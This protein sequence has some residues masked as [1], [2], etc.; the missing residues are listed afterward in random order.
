MG[1]GLLISMPVAPTAHTI[2]R[3]PMRLPARSSSTGK[4]YTQRHAHVQPS[5]LLPRCSALRPTRP[6]TLQCS[7]LPVLCMVH[8]VIQ[9]AQV[10]RAARSSNRQSGRPTCP[11]HH[12]VADELAPG[13]LLLKYGACHSRGVAGVQLRAANGHHGQ[14]HGEDEATYQLCQAGVRGCQTCRVST[15]VRQST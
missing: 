3:L 11:G 8:S 5:L 9:C 13:R 2:A 10:V 12:P 1:M 14:A 15:V 4:V 6:P 7:M